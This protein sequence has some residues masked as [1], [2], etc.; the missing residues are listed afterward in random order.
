MLRLDRK[1]LKLALLIILLSF[2]NIGESAFIQQLKSI[3][4][5]R[6]YDLDKTKKELDQIEAEKETFSSEEQHLYILLRAHSE[7]MHSNFPEAEKLLLNIID[8]EAGFN[9]KGRAHSILA[10]VLQLQGKY[11]RSYLHLDKA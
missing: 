2:A 4:S 9:Y 8:S 5:S 11:V 7:T 3:E 10:G 6:L 1:P